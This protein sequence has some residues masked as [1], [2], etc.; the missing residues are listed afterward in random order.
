[1][2]KGAYVVSGGDGVPRLVLIGTGAELGLC[3][4]AAEV[5]RAEGVAVRV[6][7]M[8][9]FE[10]FEAAPAEYRE[11]VLPAAAT[12][13]LAVEAGSTFGWARWVGDRG[14]V[15]G[16]DRFGASAPGEECLERLGFTVDNVV[17]RAKALL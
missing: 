17:A 4:A 1:V 14:A 7:S 3:A 5:L 11:S 16:I 8:P 12:A 9:S 6:V 13:R 10:L 2:Q 15:G